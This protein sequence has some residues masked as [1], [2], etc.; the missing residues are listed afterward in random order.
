MA[1]PTADNFGVT[2]NAELVAPLVLLIDT[3][4]PG[5]WVPAAHNLNLPQGQTYA[6]AYACLEND[7]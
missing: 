4:S 2:R 3:L 5:P 7:S 1:H 6:M